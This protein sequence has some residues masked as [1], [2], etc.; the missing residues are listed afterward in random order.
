MKGINKEKRILA[1]TMAAMVAIASLPA[2]AFAVEEERQGV[3]AHHLEHTAECGYQ[4]S[5]QP[6][7]HEHLEECYTEELLCGY[8]E[9]TE[10]AEADTHSHIQE[11]YRL[12][13]PH[14]RGEHDEACGYMEQQ[15]CSF[16]CQECHEALTTPA[17]ETNIPLTASPKIQRS[18]AEYDITISPPSLEFDDAYQGYTIGDGGDSWSVSP[19]T[20]NVY[21]Y[22]TKHENSLSVSLEGAAAGDFQLSH[23]ELRWD[24]ISYDAIEIKPKLG[25]IAGVYEATLKVKGTYVEKTVPV[26]FEVLAPPFVAVSSI[27]GV[28]G[29]MMSASSLPLNGTVTPNNA[30][31]QTIVWSI[32][33]SGTTGAQI[34]SGNI[35]EASKPGTVTVKAT[36][37][38]GLEQGKPFTETFLITVEPNAA[39]IPVQ[40]ITKAPTTMKAGQL[41]TL[42]GKVEPSNATYKTIE[43]SIV[44]NGST[45][46]NLSEGNILRASQEGTVT[47]KATIKDGLGKGKDFNKNYK[48]TV[49]PNAAFIPVE[50]ITGT[51]NKVEAKK[52]LTLTGTVKPDN[53]TNQTILWSIDAA[54]NTGAEINNGV[55]TASRK[56][57]VAVRATI[58]DGLATGSD[59]TKTFDISVNSSSSSFEPVTDIINVP[60]SVN[61][62]SGMIR[63]NDAAKVIPESATNKTIRWTLVDSQNTKISL[64]Y[65]GDLSVKKLS[66]SGTITLKATIANG[67]TQGNFEKLFY[68]GVEGNKIPDVPSTPKPDKPD[69]SEL[70]SNLVETSKEETKTSNVDFKPVTDTDDGQFSVIIRKIDPLRDGW[71]FDE[72]GKLK[73]NAMLN[74]GNQWISAEKLEEAISQENNNFI[75]MNGGGKI[76]FITSVVFSHDDIN[77]SNNKAGG[78]DTKTDNIDFTENHIIYRKF[79]YSEEIKKYSAFYSG[80]KIKIEVNGDQYTPSTPK[81]KI[82]YPDKKEVRV[83]NDGEYQYSPNEEKT[84]IHFNKDGGGE[85]D[86]F[87]NNVMIGG[88]VKKA[89]LTQEKEQS[90]ETQPV[91]TEAV[92]ESIYQLVQ[93]LQDTGLNMDAYM[94]AINL[95]EASEEELQEI[96]GKLVELAVLTQVKATIESKDIDN[97]LKQAQETPQEDLSSDS[98]AAEGQSGSIILLQDSR[99]KSDSN[100]MIVNNGKQE[101]VITGN[102]YFIMPNADSLSAISLAVDPATLALPDLP[103][104]SIFRP[105][106]VD[107]QEGLMKATVSESGIQMAI[108][109]A[110]ELAKQSGMEFNGIGVMINLTMPDA[111]VNSKALTLSKDAC[112]KMETSG[113]KEL[114]IVTEKYYLTLD[115][116]ALQ[117]IYACAGD[118]TIQVDKLAENQLSAAAQ[119][120]FHGRPAYSLTITSGG[121]A[122]AGFGQGNAAFCFFYDVKEGE[123]GGCLQMAHVNMDGLVS[124]I[125]KSVYNETKNAIYGQISQSGVYGVMETSAAEFNDISNHWA[126]VDI[127]YAASRNLLSGT[128][129]GQFSPNTEMTRGMFITTLYR[130]A[131]SPEAGEASFTDVPADAYYAD[132]AAWAMKNGMINKETTALEPGQ[133]IT[134]Q[135]AA[136]LLQRYAASIG[137]RLPKVNEAILFADEGEFSAWTRDA[138]RDMQMA[139]VL[140]G[141]QS[142][143]FEP[144][145]VITR[146]ETAAVLRRFEEAAIK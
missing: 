3:C 115:E 29:S 72:T 17:A 50:S 141:K 128:A 18:Q 92:I 47:V 74:L 37:K 104:T 116:K 30:T 117:A 96:E 32:E 136:V 88:L 7:G 93:Q 105:K 20:I 43:W 89:A 113:L 49:E 131:G 140:S 2:M 78:M 52:T 64:D 91:D 61:S 8:G 38:D 98:T 135:E 110:Q 14:E 84:N 48:I 102:T 111:A 51:P 77:E 4:E 56:G 66:P 114:D 63:L 134:R 107:V 58:K 70:I 45:R 67:T 126:R 75:Q 109:I 82:F 31:N 99:I 40:N 143:Y 121:K 13:C 76:Q 10:A 85:T 87:N 108:E 16:I 55:L 33:D 81:D 59:Y 21:S 35:L 100:I 25:L 86:A 11:C 5:S 12:D 130:F 133:A 71:F 132:A 23:N 144:D 90:Q 97:L 39:F 125:D 15:P 112:K 28:P 129:A 27:T 1:M 26:R 60:T 65:S 53:A 73:T 138:V 120:A 123:Q 139:G 127:Q 145:G 124:P 6:C 44:D 22:G 57:K 68:I 69:I 83:L 46:A 19:F 9:E 54:G 34:V 142:N 119:K 94:D 24:G 79:T 146:A 118:V 106:A 80:Q 122:V 137:L 95:Q 41:L 101:Q 36:I 62:D 42:T 103:A